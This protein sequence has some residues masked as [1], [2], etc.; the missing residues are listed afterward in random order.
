LLS[1]TYG[2]KNIISTVTT[3]RIPIIAFA[4]SL[5]LFTLALMSKH[6]AEINTTEKKLLLYSV[7]S[8]MPVKT[9]GLR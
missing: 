3:A 1:L 2:D 4:A 6:S 7:A 5:Q 8:F 9:T